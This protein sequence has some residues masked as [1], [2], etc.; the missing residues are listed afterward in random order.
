MCKSQSE[1]THITKFIKLQHSKEF[2]NILCSLMIYMNKYFN[3][4]QSKLIKTSV[5]NLLDHL[6]SQYYSLVKAFL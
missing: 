4:D 2:E 3:I 6:R 5:F 1:Q